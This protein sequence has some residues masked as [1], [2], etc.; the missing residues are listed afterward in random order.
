[1]SEDNEEVADML[2]MWGDLG[3]LTP[4]GLLVLRRVIDKELADRAGRTEDI[5][6]FKL[7]RV[8]TDAYFGP[9][10]VSA[11]WLVSAAAAGD[12][13]R[14]LPPVVEPV[15]SKTRRGWRVSL[16]RVFTPEGLQALGHSWD[17]AGRSCSR[18]Y[19]PFSEAPGPCLPPRAALE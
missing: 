2:G 7:E 1:M 12:I 15:G 8:S 19:T 5:P 16:Q 10:V 3:R 14:I 4:T 9:P 6:I 11:S 17:S 18:C 13:S